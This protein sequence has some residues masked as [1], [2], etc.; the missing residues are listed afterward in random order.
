[1]AV[2]ILIERSKGV[3]VRMIMPHVKG[4]KG[5]CYD[6]RGEETSQMS[7]RI[8][9]DESGSQ[10]AGLHMDRPMNSFS[11]R[12]SRQTSLQIHFWPEMR[13]SCVGYQGI[14]VYEH[15]VFQGKLGV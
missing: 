15:T 7:L 9:V 12:D 5:V 14:Q 8:Q 6:Q 2:L 11:P 10:I 4:L 1:M 3:L 13:T